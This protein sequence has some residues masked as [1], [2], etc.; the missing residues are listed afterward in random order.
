MTTP[1]IQNNSQNRYTNPNLI[2]KLVTRV[3][4]FFSRCVAA[5]SSKIS[6]MVSKISQ[7]AS[8]IL[9]QSKEPPSHPEVNGLLDNAKHVSTPIEAPNNL[10]PNELEQ[11]LEKTIS[12]DIKEEKNAQVR[13]SKVR[14]LFQ[15][16]IGKQMYKIMPC[17]EMKNRVLNPDLKSILN[18]VALNLNH[19]IV[20]DHVKQYTDTNLKRLSEFQLNKLDITSLLE[21]FEARQKITKDQLKSTLAKYVLDFIDEEKLVLMDKILEKTKTLGLANPN[22]NPTYEKVANYLLTYIEEATCTLDADN[23]SKI[24]CQFIGENSCLN[25]NSDFQ[26]KHIFYKNKLNDK[27]PLTFNLNS[28]VINFCKQMEPLKIANST[29]LT[30]YN[31]LEKKLEDKIPEDIKKEKNA[32]VR[33]NNLREDY[34]K[35]IATIR[36]PLTILLPKLYAIGIQISTIEQSPFN[37]EQHKLKIKEIETDV[38]NLKAEFIAAFNELNSIQQQ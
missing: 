17:E 14:I 22:P 18:P 20:P 27:T 36:Q 9:N 35:A 24:L 21:L 5:V 11:K 13:K 8:K 23:F 37:E 26:K 29:F 31:E 4:N 15:A 7:V 34:K 2:T 1:P 16:A 10:F 25:E 6:A 30:Q 33:M 28:Q 38:L 32:Q 12:E 3:V 19:T